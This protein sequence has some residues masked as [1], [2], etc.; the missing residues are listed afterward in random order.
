MCGA[1]PPGAAPHVFALPSAKLS[2]HPWP[3]T[4]H[5]LVPACSSSAAARLSCSASGAF[6]GSPLPPIARQVDR[7]NWYLPRNCPSAETAVGSPPDSHSAIRA[8]S[9]DGALALDVFCAVSAE[10]GGGLRPDDA[11]GVEAVLALE[12]LDGAPGLRP[13]DAVGLQAER[14]LDGGD[15]DARHD[16]L[17][18]A[19]RRLRGGRA[20]GAG[21][22]S[23][24]ARPPRAAGGGAADLGMGRT[25]TDQLSARMNLAGHHAYGVS[26]RARALTCA[27]PR[28]GGDSP[29]EPQAPLGPPLPAAPGV[30]DSAGSTSGRRAYDPRGRNASRRPGQAANSAARIEVRGEPAQ[31][32]RLARRASAAANAAAWPAARSSG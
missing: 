4:G 17:R 1:A 22:A 3:Q 6:A 28:S 16:G 15:V 9:L 5:G 21:R 20:A 29:Q 8:S 18:P 14:R 25:G 11:V 30:R 13:V 12:A 23:A 26:C 31:R 24:R 32:R 27:T 19:G 2:S 10:R 7:E